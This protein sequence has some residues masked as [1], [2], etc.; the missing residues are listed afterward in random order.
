MTDDQRRELNKLR[1]K[2]P[3]EA[4]DAQLVSGLLAIAGLMQKQGRTEARDLLHRVIAR[5]EGKEFDGVLT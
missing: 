4:H 1:A 3:I 5:I 2:G